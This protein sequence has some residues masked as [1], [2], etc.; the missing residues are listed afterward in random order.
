MYNEIM[1]GVYGEEG[2]EILSDFMLS[3]DPMV[4]IL[5]E[6]SSMIALC[7]FV[8]AIV[9]P[10]FAYRQY[11]N[12]AIKKIRYEYS[13]DAQPQL[14]LKGGTSGGW[15][16]FVAAVYGCI[17]F[18]FIILIASWF[19][20]G[21]YQK[22]Q[23]DAKANSNNGYHQETPFGDDSFGLDDFGELW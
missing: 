13:K 19:L 16:A 12:F 9:L 4:F 15:V 23:D 2:L 21:M 11:K 14:T 7:G 22:A 6:I 8:L 18:A 20:N 17:C 10:F 5:D 3:G 1:N